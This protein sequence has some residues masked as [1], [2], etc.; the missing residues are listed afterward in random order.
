VMK[1]A[2]TQMIRSQLRLVFDNGFHPTTG[3]IMLKTK[4]F[5]N[6]KTNAE[7]DQLWAV[8]QAFAGLQTLPLHSVERTDYSEIVAS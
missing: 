3:D 5:N 4:T 2:E 7:P 1:L 6:V 8:A